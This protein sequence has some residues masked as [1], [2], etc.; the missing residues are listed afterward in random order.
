MARLAELKKWSMAKRRIDALEN[1]VRLAELKK[2]AMAKRAA[3]TGLDEKRLAELKKWSMA[4]PRRADRILQA[5]W[6]NSKSGLWQSA[7]ALPSDGAEVG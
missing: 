7:T 5:G 3:T 1:A 4:K 6:L 2:W